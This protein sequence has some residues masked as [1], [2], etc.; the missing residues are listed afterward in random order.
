[1]SVPETG[2]ALSR[3][4]SMFQLYSCNYSYKLKSDCDG[5]TVRD[6]LSSYNS[7]KTCLKKKGSNKAGLTAFDGKLCDWPQ[8]QLV[9]SVKW[10]EG[11]TV[12]HVGLRVQ[13][14]RFQWRTDTGISCKSSLFPHKSPRLCTSCQDAGV[15]MSA[16]LGQPTVPTE[17]TLATILT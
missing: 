9:I 17:W 5:V 14:S 6:K 7:G 12:K 15:G 10:W 2:S 3:Q 4:E 13:Q 11:V 16:L 1:M 8:W